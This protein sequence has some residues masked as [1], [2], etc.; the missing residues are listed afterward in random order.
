MAH[1]IFITHIILSAILS[2]FPY[3]LLLGIIFSVLSNVSS[4]S[5]NRT[6]DDRLGDPI[7]G[8]MPI[9]N[10][11]WNFGPECPVC[12]VLPNINKTFDRTWH[13]C[14]VYPTD[15]APHTVSLTFNGTA[16]WVYCVI[17]NYVEYAITLTNV[18]INLDG[19]NVGI[20]T[21][22][23]EEDTSEMIY[24]VSV[25]TNT[26]LEN[27]LHTIVLEPLRQTNSSVFLFDWAQYTFESDELP[28]SQS[29]IPPSTV[30]T[31]SPATP[32]HTARLSSNAPGVNIAGL[33]AGVTVGAV[34]LLL[35]IATFL[36]WRRRS[37]RNKATQISVGESVTPLQYKARA[38]PM[39]SKATRSH[40]R[41]QDPSFTDLHGRLLSE[42]PHT[43]AI[44]R[45]AG[46]SGAP[47]VTNPLVANE[48]SSNEAMLERRVEDIQSELDR[49]RAIVSLVAPS[50][51]P[52][53]RDE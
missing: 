42:S 34:V 23:P 33:A 31:T 16:I 51:P 49:L 14:T 22:I 1:S 21:H 28:S 35:S 27:T 25:Y 40:P 44:F 8:L 17:P 43:S 7:T 18:S 32:A 26:N 39:R 45:S 30:V 52:S 19:E 20:Y 6:I 36:Y 2:D 3:L 48:Y 41:M 13:D 5:V 53:Y 47:R 37:D 12:I 38:A 15:T 46:S 50:A 24:N 10:G 11:S 4:V 29:S 9:Y